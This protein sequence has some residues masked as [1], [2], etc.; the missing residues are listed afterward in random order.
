MTKVTRATPVVI[1]AEYKSPF[2]APS[3]AEALSSEQIYI[4]VALNKSNKPNM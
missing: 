1:N 3:S 2:I 4:A